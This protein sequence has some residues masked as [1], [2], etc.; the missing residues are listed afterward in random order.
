MEL[1]KARI[2]RVWAE[3]ERYTGVLLEVAREVADLYQRPGQ[4][5][6]VHR[7]EGRTFLALASAP[8]EHAA[9]E[10]LLGPPALVELKPELDDEWA[11][12]PP[13]GPGFPIE[14]ARGRDSFI[15]GVGTGVAPLRALIECM[16]RHRKLYQGITLYAGASRT[17]DHAYRA[18]DALWAADGIVVRRVVSKPF[19]QDVLRADQP[20][21]ERAEAFVCGHREMVTEVTDTLEQLGLTKDRV[22]L[23][24]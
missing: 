20:A 11:I 14:A 24:F 15:L 23:N 8:G 16:R 21:L 4:Y 22:H 17:E 12:E 19:V 1:A 18:W 10:L 2:R 5:I 7:P 9:L 13:D 3:S 6:V